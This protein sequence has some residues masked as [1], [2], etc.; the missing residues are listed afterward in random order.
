MG[1]APYRRCSQKH[2]VHQPY[3]LPD[4][5]LQLSQMGAYIVSAIVLVIARK[6]IYLFKLSGKMISKPQAAKLPA[7]IVGISRN[8]QYITRRLNRVFLQPCLVGL[9]F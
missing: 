6:H 8:D 5:F 3:V 4:G 7:L 2:D 1:E 9:K